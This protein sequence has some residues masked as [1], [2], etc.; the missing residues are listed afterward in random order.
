MGDSGH[1]N[2]RKY[3]NSS[4]GMDGLEFRKRGRDMVDYIVDYLV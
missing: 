3:K 2:Q 4:Y 1:I